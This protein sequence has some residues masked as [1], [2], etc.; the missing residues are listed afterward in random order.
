MNISDN[1]RIWIYQ[2]N[3]FL[4]TDEEIQITDQLAN[5]TGQWQAHGQ[6]LT[7]LGEIKHHLFIILSIDEQLISATGCSIDKSVSLIKKIEQ[8]FGITL[9]DRFQVAFR[10]G[11]DIKCCNQNQFIE[12]L[13]NGTISEEVIVFNNLVATRKAL[14]TDWEVPFK[15]SW[16]AQV[17][18]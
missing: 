4:T 18:L 14:K 15:E 17:F 8:Q 13:N 1:A 9:F 2:S 3:R 11:T 12:L 5:F 16:H 10:M 6:T 7:A